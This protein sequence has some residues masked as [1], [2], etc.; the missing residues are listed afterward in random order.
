MSIYSVHLEYL[1]Q[2]SIN[3]HIENHLLFCYVLMY[4]QNYVETCLCMCVYTHT[5]THFLSHDYSILRD[6]HKLT[7]A[8]KSMADVH[9]TNSMA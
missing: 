4:I 7:V 6:E 3:I 2:R 1:G 8:D 5:H 9:A